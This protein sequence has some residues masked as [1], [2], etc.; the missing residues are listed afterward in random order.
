MERRAVAEQ[1]A[2]ESSQAQ[3]A[4][5]DR[6]DPEGC[7]AW[8]PQASCVHSGPAAQIEPLK[9][10]GRANSTDSF[11]WSPTKLIYRGAGPTS[12]S[13]SISNKLERRLWDCAF[14]RRMKCFCAWLATCVGV[15]VF[16]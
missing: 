16:T 5:S 9:R 10:R 1:Q 14:V 15:R 4:L 7:W 8:L 13:V 12:E 3:D 11:P 6:L 2:P